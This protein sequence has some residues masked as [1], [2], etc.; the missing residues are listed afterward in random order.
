MGFN[1]TRRK[2]KVEDA[3]RKFKILKLKTLAKRV[4]SFENIEIIN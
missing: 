3:R 1:Y 4:F 2:G